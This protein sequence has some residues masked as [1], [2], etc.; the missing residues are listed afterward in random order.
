MDEKKL[1]RKLYF[2]V[3]AV[4]L[5]VFGL[6][7]TSFALAGSIAHVRNN[8]F[9]MSMGVE[10]NIN[11]GKPVVDVEDV[12]YEPGGTYKGE[13]SLAN[14]STFDVWYR[15]YFTDVDGV[16]DDYITVTIKEK[17]GTVL[18]SGTMGEISA[19][20][21]MTSTLAA[22]EKKTLDIEFAF[23]ES[24]GN[25]AQGKTVAFNITA[26]ATQKQ[27]NPYMLFGD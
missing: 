22:G 1:K 2:M 20:K 11:D 9:A 24:A 6:T 10:L 23:A 5:L 15:V 19:D 3:V 18:C 17:D 13:F 25:E 7:I 14:L 12:V 26:D 27:N 21:V 8:R 16:L 4:V